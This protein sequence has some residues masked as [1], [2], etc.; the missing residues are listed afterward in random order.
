MFPSQGNLYVA[1]FM[2]DALY[3]EHYSKA[4]FW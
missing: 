2:D 4:N 1:P 3:M